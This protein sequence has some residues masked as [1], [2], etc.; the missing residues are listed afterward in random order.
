MGHIER[1]Q[2]LYTAYT[3]IGWTIKCHE[4][5]GLDTVCETF[6]ALEKEQENILAELE[7]LRQE[8]GLSQKDFQLLIKRKELVLDETALDSD[9]FKRCVVKRICNL[10]LLGETYF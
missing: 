9:K 6:K 4:N 2:Q 10:H 3:D 1:M 8:A 5:H 7:K